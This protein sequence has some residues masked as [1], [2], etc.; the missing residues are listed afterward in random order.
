M[1]H[2]NEERYQQWCAE[3]DALIESSLALGPPKVGNDP[4]LPCVN[5]EGEYPVSPTS[6]IAT[7]F[8]SDED[9]VTEID[10]DDQYSQQ[11]VQWAY[12]AEGYYE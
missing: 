10:E 12:M 2:L 6:S 7:V 3:A 5:N 11:V 9:R 4:Y 1:P 8:L